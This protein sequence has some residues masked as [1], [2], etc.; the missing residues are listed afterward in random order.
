M[1]Q[2]RPLVS[3]GSRLLPRRL[4]PALIAVAATV[5]ST[6]VTIAMAVIASIIPIASSIHTPIH[7][8]FVAV[9]G[10]FAAGEE[11]H[12]SGDAHDDEQRFRG[13][14]HGAGGLAGFHVLSLFG[15]LMAKINQRAD[16]SYE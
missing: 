5:V 13:T 3:H 16:R 15:L 14:L 4:V 8:V 6:F 9:D 12:G 7:P 2:Q 10:P 1:L 11:G